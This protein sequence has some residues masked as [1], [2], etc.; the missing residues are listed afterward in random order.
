MIV[1]PVHLFE[2]DTAL[3]LDVRVVGSERRQGVIVTEIRYAAAR[4][5]DV[6]ALV[7][8]ADG[9][10]AGCPGVV[11][12]HGGKRPKKE[13]LLDQ[14]I[15]LAQAGFTVLLADTNVPPRGDADV[16]ERAFADAVLVQRRALDVLAAHGAAR[17][18]YFGYS[19]GGSQGAVLSAVEPRLEAVAIAASGAGFADSFRAE[20]VTDEGWLA[21]ID[22]LDPVHYVSVPG[23][24]HLLLQHGTDDDTVPIEAGRALFAAAAEPKEWAEYAGCDHDVNAFAPALADRIAFFRHGL[25]RR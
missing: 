14:G 3:P 1:T 17:L 9:A 25:L 13:R 6:A 11:Y 10:P 4:G 18:G 21:R 7:V 23:R 19:F 8:E 20:G 2:Y 5:G 15:A 16:D 24:R 22:R 12:A